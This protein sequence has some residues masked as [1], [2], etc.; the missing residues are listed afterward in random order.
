MSLYKCFPN[1]RTRH[2]DQHAQSFHISLRT[3]VLVLILPW[4][5][6]SVEP[7]GDYRH[8]QRTR[9]GVMDV[10]AL[11]IG[12]RVA[13]TAYRPLFASLLVDSSQS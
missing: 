6:V 11:F 3:K 13:S 7:T 10:I 5:A 12:P 4:Q 9:D 2:N 1:G 8:C